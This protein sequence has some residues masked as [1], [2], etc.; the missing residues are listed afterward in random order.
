VTQVLHVSLLALLALALLALPITLVNRTSLLHADEL[1]GLAARWRRRL[2]IDVA[3]AYTARLAFP[4]VLSLAALLGGAL[5][6]LLV[7]SFGWDASS[8]ALVLGLT[9]GL[10]VRSS[11]AK[12]AERAAL[13]TAGVPT[14]LRM[15][16]GFAVLAAGC[17]V[18][19]RAAGLQPGLL[20]GTLIALVASGRVR[21]QDQ[22]RAAAIAMAALAALA[23]VC[24]FGRAD[25]VGAAGR[26]G[27]FCGQV[28]DVA[29]SA[30]VVGGAQIL[31]FEMLP[32]A[33]LDG[34]LIYR[35]NRLAW[36]GLS[37]AGAFGFVLVLLRPAGSAASLASRT[38]Y[39]LVLLGVYLLLAVAFW[40]WFRYRPARFRPAS[41]REPAPT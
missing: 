27:G 32:L 18:M 29:T 2:R 9:V 3:S 30:I 4:A 10:L 21:P 22:G 31:A 40:S 41:D 37:F 6:A 23:A 26:W 34:L 1:A 16:P 28:V 24:W 17:V 12:G 39:L 33:F 35:W 11:V 7:P 25:L 14:V 13:R 15:Y 38:G 8:L 5:Y 20:L 19:S 36:A